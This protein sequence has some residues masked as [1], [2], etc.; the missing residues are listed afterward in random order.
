MDRS[1]RQSPFDV[2]RAALVYSGRGATVV[3]SPID[4]SMSVLAAADRPITSFAMGSPA[5]DAIPIVDIGD[6][7]ERVLSSSTAAGALDYSP[8]EGNPVLRRA[9][10]GRLH[11]QGRDVHPD[12]LLI[13]A[14]GMQGLDLVYRLFLEPGDLVLA[15]SPSY[16]NGTAT[17]RNHGARLVQVPLDDE[18][19]DIEAARRT[20]RD[21]GQA[22]KLLYL[23]PTYQNPSG[24]SYTVTRRLEI[25]ALAREV[26]ALVVEDDPYSELRYEGETYPSLQ[27]LD[28]DQGGVIQVRTFSKIVAPG[29][30]VGWLVAPRNVVARMV[31]LRQTMDTCANSLGQIIVADLI[32]NDRLGAHIERLIALYPARRDAMDRALA[33]AFGGIDGIT[34]TR[35]SGGMF[36]WLDLPETIDG[37]AVLRAGLERGV[38]VVP[39]SAF[40]PERAKHALR[41]C[42]SAVAEA[43]IDEGIGR[44]GATVEALLDDPRSPGRPP[45]VPAPSA[46]SP[47]PARPKGRT[48]VASG[49]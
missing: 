10:L 46:G 36:T 28:E 16:A 29:L 27:E 33:S 1:S 13:T 24:R 35:P 38:A 5:P 39:G 18:G 20:I 22:P 30:R 34:W 25:L 7:L 47:P 3:G 48:R 42:F 12:C 21:L 17:A 15:E 45:H 9:L 32:E 6:A 4:A 41:L 8:T 14:G 2:E 43:D 26:G 40:D 23:I 19:L 44:L 31:D 37:D 49:L 11:R